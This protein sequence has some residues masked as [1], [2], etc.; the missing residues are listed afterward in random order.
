MMFLKPKEMKMQ[1]KAELTKCRE[2]KALI[3]LNGKFNGLEVRPAELYELA[4]KLII[5]AGMAE[6]KPLDGKQWKPEEVTIY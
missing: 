5:L 2:N 6:R 4:E 3:V 1:V